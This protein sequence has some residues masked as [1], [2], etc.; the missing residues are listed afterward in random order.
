M[1]TVK[2]LRLPSLL[3]FL[4]IKQY[5]LLALRDRWSVSHMSQQQHLNTIQYFKF[6]S[7]SF[8][9]F[10]CLHSTIFFKD[11]PGRGGQTWDPLVFRL[12][13]LTSNALD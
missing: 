8:T 3:K 7:Y 2:K 6:N 10:Y 12:F 9:K 11:C 4:N 5:E 1:R 13:S